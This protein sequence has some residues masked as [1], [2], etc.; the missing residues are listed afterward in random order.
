MPCTRLLPV[1]VKILDVGDPGEGPPAL[2]TSVNAAREGVWAWR[3]KYFLIT[4]SN[5]ASVG[6]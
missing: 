3:L 1:A 2:V 6:T 4:F 5:F